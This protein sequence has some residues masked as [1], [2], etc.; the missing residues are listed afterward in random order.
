MPNKVLANL[1]GLDN[2][3]VMPACLYT[4]E[5]ADDIC[6]RLVEDTSLRQVA[7]L[8]GMPDRATI[9]RWLDKYPDFAAKYARARESQGDVLDDEIQREADEASVEDWQVRKLRIETMKWRAAK[10]A[11]KKYGD[12]LALGGHDGGPLQVVVQKFTEGET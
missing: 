4:P 11:P 1:H 5:L 2:I 6:S 9:L 12:K 7:L 3:D 10:L 8:P